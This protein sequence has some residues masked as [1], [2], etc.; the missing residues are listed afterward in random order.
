[1]VT[2]SELFQSVYPD[3]IGEMERIENARGKLNDFQLML[4][5]AHAK[6]GLGV[7][8]YERRQIINAIFDSFINLYRKN[9][10]MSAERWAKETFGCYIESELEDVSDVVVRIEE[11]HHLIHDRETELLQ[12]YRELYMLENYTQKDEPAPAVDSPSGEPNASNDG[13]RS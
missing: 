4:A 12:M 1:M 11:L 13:G 6:N 5:V 8:S 3:L 10:R 7:L 2:E 9:G